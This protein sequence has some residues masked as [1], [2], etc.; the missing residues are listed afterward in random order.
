LT[1][2][3]SQPFTGEPVEG[4][5]DVKL[6]ATIAD[7]DSAALACLYDRYNRI[8]FTTVLRIVKDRDEAEDVLVEV[9][10]EVWQK[11]DRYNAA[12][13]NPL[14]YLLTMA[15][16][17]AV[18][19]LRSRLRTR[20]AMQAMAASGATVQVQE[21][22]ATPTGSPDPGAQASLGEQRSRVVAALLSLEPQQREVVELSFYDGLSHSE[23]ATR[24]NKPLG[25]VKTYIRQGLARLR[26]R[27]RSRRED[28]NA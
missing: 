5:D 7:G 22:V 21:S 20:S 3:A 25:T 23:I 14:T 2:S 11:S 28:V 15:R 17:R 10:H 9:F 6:M 24:L 18:D 27:L 26:D 1:T 4:Q 16:S 19:H 13:G 12:R 8:V